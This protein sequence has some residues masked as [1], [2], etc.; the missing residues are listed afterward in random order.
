MQ[1]NN[2]TMKAGAVLLAFA[3]LAAAYWPVLRSGFVYDDEAYVVNNA[4]VN[5]P[6]MR[7]VLCDYFPPGA[8]DTGLYRPMVTASYIVDRLIAPDLNRRARMAHLHNLALHACVAILLFL[9]LHR[10]AGFI[11]AAIGFCAYAFHPLLT[12]SVAWVSGRSELLF[13]IWLLIGLHVAFLRALNPL[14]RAFALGLA[15]VLALSA[16]ESAVMLPAGVAAA[17]W[18]LRRDIRFR[19]LALMVAPSILVAA[20]YLAARFFIVGHI[21]PPIRAFTGVETGTRW[22][23]AG[24]AFW[25]YLVLLFVPAGQTVH[26]PPLP[27]VMNMGAAVAGGIALTTTI[28]FAVAGFVRRRAWA[29]VP[30]WYLLLLLPYSNLALPI[31][32]IFA[33]RFLY[34]PAL[35]LG[36][37]AALMARAAIKTG[38]RWVCGVIMGAW[39]AAALVGG[40]ATRARSAEWR[41]D[42]ALWRSAAEAYPRDVMAEVAVVFHLVKRGDRDSMEEAVARWRAFGAEVRTYPRQVFLIPAIA[43]R[44]R[45]LED[46]LAEYLAA[47]AQPRPVATEMDK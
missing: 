14:A 45:W 18:L 6:T 27:I 10:I 24:M 44:V 29:L 1:I 11:A 15:T 40:F 9:L 39:L 17:V 7:N 38:D 23:I 4:A 19:D 42:V 25:H 33:E 20:G 26:W 31:G 13:G 22:V 32:S 47:Q 35:A 28:G 34:A 30:A 2:A 21:S 3:L 37:G 16:K 43:Q 41:D 36:I 5:T 46:R 12:E 8:A